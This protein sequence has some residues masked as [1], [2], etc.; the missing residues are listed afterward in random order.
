L[1][2]RILGGTAIEGARVAL[3]E[4]PGEAEPDNLSVR[5]ALGDAEAAVRA[6]RES[7]VLGYGWNPLA[8]HLDY[9]WDPIRTR[10]SFLEWITPK[11]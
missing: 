7:F 1:R 8:P 11:G 5:A 6:L 9:V 2:C 10:S 3:V 4:R